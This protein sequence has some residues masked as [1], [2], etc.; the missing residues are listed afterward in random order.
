LNVLNQN[1]A[2]GAR[3]RQK[4]QTRRNVLEAARTLFRE[5]GFEGATARAIAGRAGV[6]VGTVFVH[7]GDKQG[8]LEAC[9]EDHI[10]RVLDHAFATVPQGDVVSELVYVSGRLF[11]SYARDPGLSRV[12]VKEA[13]FR[14][15]LEAGEPVRGGGQRARLGAWM[16]ERLARAVEGGELAGGVDPSQVFFSFFAL[17]LAV[18]AAGLRGD[19]PFAAQ[20]ALLESLLR[21]LAFFSRGGVRS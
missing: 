7:F 1:D 10:E 13:V 15:P 19:V 18:L 8:L 21:Q 2:P 20:E 14:A 16:N 11:E 3:A 17:Y 12:L 5:R 4:A 6:S 9:L